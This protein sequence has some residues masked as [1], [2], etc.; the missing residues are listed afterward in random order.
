M[1]TEPG[2][3][4]ALLPGRTPKEAQMVERYRVLQQAVADAQAR[5]SIAHASPYGLN[6]KH[7]QEHAALRKKLLK[8]KLI[9]KLTPAQAAEVAKLQ[10]EAHD[11]LSGRDG[12]QEG[13]DDAEVRS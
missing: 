5:K 7:R 10:A 2:N 1:A 9:V 12:P 3:Q 11:G 4:A 6:R 13:R 8:L